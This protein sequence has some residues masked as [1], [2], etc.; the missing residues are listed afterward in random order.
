MNWKM[1]L[2]KRYFIWKLDLKNNHQI[3]GKKK[4]FTNL[5]FQN[6]NQKT[7]ETW[8]PIV[9]TK[10][11]SHFQDLSLQT[12]VKAA[13]NSYDNNGLFEIVKINL[14]I[15][16]CW[17]AQRYHRPSCFV[18]RDSTC[19]IHR[20]CFEVKR[21]GAVSDP[22]QFPAYLARLPTLLLS[23]KALTWIGSGIMSGKM[24]KSCNHPLSIVM[25]NMK[26]SE[27]LDFL[28]RDYPEYAWNLPTLDRRM[29][30]FDIKNYETT[31]D[32]VVAASNTE[33]DCPGQLFGYRT[34][35]KKLREQHGLAVPHVFFRNS[36]INPRGLVGDVMTM[37]CPEGLECGKNIGKKERTWG[38]VGTFTLLVCVKKIPSSQKFTWSYSGFRE[39]META[40]RWTN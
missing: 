39:L 5:W 12:R 26:R 37:E 10:I 14:Q 18:G 1:K 40:N 21:I 38:P 13:S 24:T 16:R 7:S 29:R 8:Q 34:L 19:D 22:S 2:Q 33:N 11:N 6:R 36:V 32:E 4:T 9:V 3:S 35:H 28:K 27:A 20:V 17:T 25:Q 31:V 30:Y 23:W 15:K